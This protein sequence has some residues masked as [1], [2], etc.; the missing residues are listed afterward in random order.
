M[1]DAPFC[2][3]FRRSMNSKALIRFTGRRMLNAFAFF[4]PT[5]LPRH[6]SARSSLYS[7]RYFFHNRHPTLH[8]QKVSSRRKIRRSVTLACRRLLRPPPRTSNS[9]FCVLGLTSPL[10]L[11]FSPVLALSPIL[12]L[13]LVLLSLFF[14]IKSASRFFVNSSA[15][16]LSFTSRARF[17]SASLRPLRALKPDRFRLP[18]HFS[19]FSAYSFAANDACYRSITRR[20]LRRRRR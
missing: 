18:T 11:L 10:P 4:L 7:Q 17:S 8:R 13:V 16:C 20:R 6:S 12:S 9:T 5:P 15:F 1:V 14:C 2:L 19:R 3:H